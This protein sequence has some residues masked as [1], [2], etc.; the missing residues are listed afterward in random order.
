MNPQRPEPQ[1]GALPIEL[2]PPQSC[3]IYIDTDFHGTPEGIRT[4]D[5]QL[6]R[7]MLYPTELRADRNSPG[8]PLEGAWSGWRDSNSRHPAPKAGALPDCATPRGPRDHTT[9]L[10]TH[11]AAHAARASPWST[12]AIS[13]F[14][15]ITA[16]N[17]LPLPSSEL[18]SSRP[19]CRN[20]T[21]L[22]IARPRPVPPV[23]RERLLSTR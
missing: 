1:S 9:A 22:T 13:R 10:C 20:S 18:T 17:R 14:A 23:S 5:P 11:S 4:P 2:H 12:T 19:S 6:R 15:G 8:A 16:L 21:C 3:E 7:L